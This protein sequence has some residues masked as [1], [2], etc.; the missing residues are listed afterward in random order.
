M[1]DAIPR[2][3]NARGRTPLRLAAG[4][5]GLL[6]A[7]LTLAPRPTGASASLPPIRHIWIVVMENEGIASTFDVASSYLGSLTHRGA[8]VDKYYAVA[9]QSL[10]NYIAL[11][12]GQGPTPQTQGD[13]QVYQDVTPG[14][15]ASG[16]GHQA[17]GDGCVYP[18]DYHTVADQLTAAGL[19]WKGYMEDM[20]LDSNRDTPVTCKSPTNNPTND[21]TQT[22]EA[23]DQYAARHDPFMYYHTIVDSPA[24]KTNVVTLQSASNGLLHDLGS[25]STTPNYSFISPNLCDDGHDSGCKGPDVA[26]DSTGGMVAVNHW[27]EAYVPP[28]LS[29]PAYK[30]DGMLV[31][32]FDEV[33]PKQADT[34]TAASCCNEPLAADGQPAGG[35][36]EGGGIVGALVLSPFVAPNTKTEN[37]YNH[38]SL[39]RTVEDV[40]HLRGGDDQPTA[41]GHVGLAGDYFAGY[42]QTPFGDDVFTNPGYVPPVETA[43]TATSIPT[44]GPITRTTTQSSSSS[45]ADQGGTQGSGFVPHQ[46]GTPSAQPS[47]K[48]G[49]GPVPAASPGWTPR[50]LASTGG[51]PGAG[52]Y[53]LVLAPLLAVGVAASLL[54]RRRSGGTS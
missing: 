8:L 10:P 4:L 49:H 12:G 54:S 3:S 50:F 40:L 9:H 41:A 24:C 26:G 29:S 7:A 51:G 33:D 22:A 25:I 47:A 2:P 53:V 20:G 42:K 34:S 39:L 5:L 23:Q 45:S 31:I 13:C 36:G 27:L 21:P 37:P 19:T 35:Y 11:I 28:I 43:T 18:T 17:Q 32:T 15:V 46:G 14:T 30:K 16:N 38:Y 6:A 1:R 52:T 44:L 48:G